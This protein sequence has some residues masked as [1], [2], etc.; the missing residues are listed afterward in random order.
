MTQ[1]HK[2]RTILGLLRRGLEST[3]LLTALAEPGPRRLLGINALL[4]S[5]GSGAAAVVL[6]FFATRVAGLSLSQLGEALAAMG[7]AQV[8]GAV[9]NGI[10]AGR[11]GIR[12]HLVGVR[13]LQAAAYL[14]VATGPSF[15]TIAA[16]LAV[17]GYAQG[18]LNGLNQVLT[19]DVLGRQNRSSA[20][21][22]IRAL[23]NIG[24]LTSGGLA[25]ALLSTGTT[26]ALRVAVEINALSFLG[27]AVIVVVVTRGSDP[28]PVR[29]DHQRA[30]PAL[31]DPKYL[32]LTA[33]SAVFSS[34]IVVLDVGI[35]LW[36]I[37]NHQIPT[38][39]AAV[40][41]MVNTLVVVLLQYRTAARTD[42]VTRARRSI[43]LSAAAFLLMSGVLATAAHLDRWLGL[44]GIALA[45][46]LLTAGEL[47]ESP[48]WWTL[49]FNH[50]PP[51]VR[52]E[53][54]ASFDL[55][56]GLVAIA[57][58]PLMVVVVQAGTV[59]WLGYGAAFVVA[60]LVGSAT[61]E[62]MVD[63]ERAE[64]AHV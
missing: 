37:K 53:Y 51:A 56:W 26:T 54:L 31:R 62:R 4:D 5:F 29:A 17:A 43:R 35:P 28:R 14:V 18:G 1:A 20:L 61:S 39:S 27:C 45:A 64:V 52:S 58:P 44:A 46:I 48:A 22:A 50:A 24:Y 8:I 60:G 15:A 23:R 59:G 63:H 16:A 25:A 36:V 13:L 21:G 30:F 2:P 42:S 7:I 12:R 33:S 41:V 47:L 40:A 19:S 57:G 10:V 9:P 34:S 32:T 6:P 11:I 38:W 3:G 55:C 49:S